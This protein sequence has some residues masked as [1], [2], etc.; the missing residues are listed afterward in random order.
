MYIRYFDILIYSQ[1]IIKLR[2]CHYTHLLA[3]EILRF[4]TVFFYLNKHHKSKIILYREI[5]I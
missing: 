5:Y 3:R 1:E 4:K 2:P